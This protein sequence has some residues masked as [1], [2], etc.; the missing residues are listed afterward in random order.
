MNPLVVHQRPSPH[1]N[2]RPV[3]VS[4]D[5]LVLHADA[6]RSEEGT[7]HWLTDPGSKVS[8]HYLVGRSGTLYQC[9]PDRRRAWHAGK[10]RLGDRENVNDFSVG[11]S[12]ANRQDGEPFPQKQITAGLAL[13]R[14]LLAVHHIPIERVVTHAQIAPGRKTDPGPLFPLAT[15]LE[16]L[17]A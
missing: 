6:G 10:S 12:F 2:A 1:H 5:C 13:C 14:E 9:V 8:Y 16:R 17:R 4:I 7:L 15:F 11:V 3:G